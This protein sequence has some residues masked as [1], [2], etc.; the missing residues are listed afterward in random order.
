VNHNFRSYDSGHDTLQKVINDC[1]WFTEK[2]CV[3][4]WTKVESI[5]IEYSPHQKVYTSVMVGCDF[6]LMEGKKLTTVKETIS[7]SDK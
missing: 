7:D 6:P 5:A 3:P 2:L 4:I 1:K